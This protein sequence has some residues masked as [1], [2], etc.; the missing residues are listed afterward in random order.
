MTQLFSKYK[1]VCDVLKEKSGGGKKGRQGASSHKIPNS[2][3]SLAC[4][5]HTLDALFK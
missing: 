1:T 2:L 3:L 5:V 4:V